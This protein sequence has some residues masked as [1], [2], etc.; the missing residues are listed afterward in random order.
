M[1]RHDV[2]ELE[3]RRVD[4][5][6]RD[7]G[8]GEPRDAHDGHVDGH[9]E[10]GVDEEEEE[11]GDR[12]DGGARPGAIGFGGALERDAVEAAEKAFLNVVGKDRR[13]VVIDELD[14]AA[15]KGPDDVPANVEADAGVGDAHD[16]EVEE[17]AGEKVHE[18]DEP[19]KEDG[20]QDVADFLMAMAMV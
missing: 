3:D 7:E 5:G 1:T 18:R 17:G 9:E 4:L 16:R 8:D 12:A 20:P 2:H 11:A 13:C 6:H 10:D 15:V 19:A 14:V